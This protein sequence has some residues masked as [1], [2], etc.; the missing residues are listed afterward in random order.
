MRVRAYGGWIALSTR[1]D[2]GRPTP[3]ISQDG[4]AAHED[5]SAAA[6]RGDREL[7][8]HADVEQLRVA[9]RPGGH[10]L[11]RGDPPR[12]LDAP[13]LVAIVAAHEELVLAPVIG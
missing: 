4:V 3:S 12:S 1:G 7:S 13:K 8:A 9:R 5:R 11:H 10:L 6:R 2:V